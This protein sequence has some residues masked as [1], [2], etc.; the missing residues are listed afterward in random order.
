MYDDE[1]TEIVDDIEEDYYDDDSKY[2][3]NDIIS[4]MYGYTRS[5]E[6]GWF[7]SDDDD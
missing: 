6:D 3:L 2:I 4:D 1:Y 7:Y 5:E